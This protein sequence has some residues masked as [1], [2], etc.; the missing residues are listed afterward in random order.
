MDGN[1]GNDS[2]SIGY[3]ESIEA[4]EKRVQYL[5]KVNTSQSKNG[6]RIRNRMMIL[7]Y[8]AWS[9]AELMSGLI[10]INKLG[11]VSYNCTHGDFFMFMPRKITSLMWISCS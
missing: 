2:V 6:S 4:A 3:L 1:D 11:Q 10:T 8:H 5:K 7:Q 9:M